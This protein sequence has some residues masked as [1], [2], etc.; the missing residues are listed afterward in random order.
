VDEEAAL[1]DQLEASYDELPYGWK[2]HGLTHPVRMGTVAA[3]RGFEPA[4]VDRCRVLEIGCAEGGNL[5]PLAE[6]YPDSEFVGIELSNR[7]AQRATAIVDELGLTNVQVHQMDVRDLDARMGHFDYVIAHGVFSW[8]PPTVQEHVL[9]VSSE[10]LTDRGLGFVSFNVYPGWHINGILRTLSLEAAAPTAPLVE[11]VRA[12]RAALARVAVDARQTSQFGVMLAQAAEGLAE[13]DDGYLA[14]DFLEPVNIPLWFGEFASRAAA[15]GLQHVGDLS[16][17]ANVS[18]SDLA[19]QQYLDRLAG[20][21][22]RAAVVCAAGVPLDDSAAAGVV[23]HLHASGH[24]TPAG[25][26]DM[27][28]GVESSFRNLDDLIATTTS[29]AV[30]L[31]LMVLT[32]RW[33]AAMPVATL[34]AEVETELSRRGV[35]APHGHHDTQVTE[36]LLAM[37]RRG[38]I[39]LST[40][41]FPLVGSVS[42]RPVVSRLNRWLA[43]SGVP[44]TNRRHGRNQLDPFVAFVAQQLDGEHDATAVIEAVVHAAESGTL[45]FWDA[46][47]TPLGGDALRVATTETV[48]DV[49]VHLAALGLLVA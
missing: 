28:E 21:S 47:G 33:P 42:E 45:S 16:I 43:G 41:A 24:L 15:H 25:D 44:C 49:L 14:H 30:K 5:L 8:V 23:G 40:E 9:R 20:T 3:L 11:R 48:P 17:R 7:Q 39:E 34:L 18:A 4:P 38:L 29:A 13:V 6:A 32:Q 19:G 35:H 1:I 37:H 2:S 27:D 31:A 10:L 22:F 12:A 36:G 26:V 46:D